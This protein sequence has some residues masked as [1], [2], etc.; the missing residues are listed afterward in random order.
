VAVPKRQ[1]EQLVRDSAQDFEDF[2]AARPDTAPHID[3]AFD[4]GLPRDEC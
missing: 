4:L 2:Y 3:V 1:A